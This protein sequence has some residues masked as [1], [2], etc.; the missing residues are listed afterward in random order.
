MI[1]LSYFRSK[2]QKQKIQKKPHKS[3]KSSQSTH[4]SFCPLFYPSKALHVLADS[5][6]TFQIKETHPHSLTHFNNNY[7]FVWNLISSTK[8]YFYYRCKCGI[9]GFTRNTDQFQQICLSFLKFWIEEYI[10][11]FSY[12]RNKRWRQ[13]QK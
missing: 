2:K 11:S 8:N 6:F 7:T 12:Q 4:S 5:G 1:I 3:H 10:N 13:S 9:Y